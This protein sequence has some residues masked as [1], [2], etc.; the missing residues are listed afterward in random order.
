MLAGSVKKKTISFTTFTFT[1][2]NP[3]LKSGP[4]GPS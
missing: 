4:L 1:N 3:H 2:A